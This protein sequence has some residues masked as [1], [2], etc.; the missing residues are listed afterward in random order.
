MQCSFIDNSSEIDRKEIQLNWINTKAQIQPTKVDP[1]FAMLRQFE[2]KFLNW[3]VWEW[4]DRKPWIISATIN[5]TV[6][7]SL[8]RILENRDFLGGVIF[9]K[10]SSLFCAV[11]SGQKIKSLERPY[12]FCWRNSKNFWEDS[13]LMELSKFQTENWQFQNRGK[14]KPC[15]ISRAVNC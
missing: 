14:L 11:K 13:K 9:M 2:T 3:D 6:E 1:Q 7:K 10:C 4:N 15:P 12:Q 5:P 8:W